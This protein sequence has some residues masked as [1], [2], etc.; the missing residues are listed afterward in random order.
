MTLSSFSV[1]APLLHQ[2]RVDQDAPGFHFFFFFNSFFIYQ[3]RVYN[4]WI[5][6]PLWT[7]FMCFISVLGNNT[8]PPSLER[9]LWVMLSY[10]KTSE[11]VADGIIPAK[12]M[13]NLWKV[14]EA[15]VECDHFECKRTLTACRAALNSSVQIFSSL[16]LQPSCFCVFCCA[17]TS[18]VARLRGKTVPCYHLS[19]YVRL[20][21]DF[22]LDNVNDQCLSVTLNTP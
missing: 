6:T 9:A 13:A 7:W 1:V 14:D 3:S 10:K 8:S 5:I 17:Y 20:L 12:W 21:C 11:I 16:F 2:P 19:L 18:M 15:G 4:C 22:G